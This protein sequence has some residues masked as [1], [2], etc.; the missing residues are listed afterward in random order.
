[1]YTSA[2]SHLGS[3]RMKSKLIEAAIAIFCSILASQFL[4]C[5]PLVALKIV[6]PDIADT[7]VR[8][9]FCWSYPLSLLFMLGILLGQWPG[10]AGASL[11]YNFLS[12]SLLLLIWALV[13]KSP[14][15]SPVFA[16]LLPLCPLSTYVLCRWHFKDVSRLLL[17]ATA[18]SGAYVA[19]NT[20]LLVSCAHSLSKLPR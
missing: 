16:C 18:L 8:G 6:P 19:Q 9:Q 1:M 2:K 20:F 10:V 15:F 5:L 4:I 7:W 11:I 3:I 12:L 14:A 13:T 17:L